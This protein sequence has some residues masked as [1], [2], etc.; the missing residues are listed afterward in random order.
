MSSRT[1]RSRPRPAALLFGPPSLSANVFE[2]WTTSKHSRAP[3]SRTFHS[4][5]TSLSYR[6]HSD[7]RSDVMKQP[8]E[9]CRSRTQPPHPPAC[10]DSL[11]AHSGCMRSAHAIRRK[12]AR[13]G[14]VAATGLSNSFTCVA[15][16]SDVLYTPSEQVSNCRDAP[17][18]TRLSSCIYVANLMQLRPLRKAVR[19]LRS[20]P[21]P[22]QGKT[23]PNQQ[24]RR[25]RV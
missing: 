7:A 12:S 10:V 13:E 25:G 8:S 17:T 21:Q 15:K 23:F 14:F 3:A 19:R 6:H 16:L 2:P 1:V 22:F 11:R 9:R 5:S 24:P 4:R 20:A 18:R